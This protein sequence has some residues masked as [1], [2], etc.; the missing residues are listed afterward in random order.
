MS[1]LVLLGGLAAAVLALSAAP[2]S[3]RDRC[4]RD[5]YYGRSSAYGYGDYGRGYESRYSRHHRWERERWHSRHHGWDRGDR[6]E[7]R[8][9]RG[10][11]GRY[12][13]GDDGGRYDRGDNGGRSD[14]DG[15]GD[16]GDR[17]GR[18]GDRDE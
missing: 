11:G 7:G 13:S 3:A 9:N 12:D 4:E 15:R 14:R 17:G 2:A 5:A 18:Y 6:Y 1:R 8:S 10:N 16:R